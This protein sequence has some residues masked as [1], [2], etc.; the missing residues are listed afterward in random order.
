MEQPF[1]T[2]LNVAIIGGGL[3]GL[4]AARVLRE[5]H[6]VTVYERSQHGGEYGAALGFGPS[7]TAILN[8]LDFDRTRVQACSMAL[9]LAYN[10]QGELI[11][12]RDTN[13]VR[14]KLSVTGEYLLSYR[15]D[16]YTE[17]LRLATM[18]SQDLS[19]TGQPATIMYGKEAVR[20]D[21]ES[22]DVS[23]ADG[24]SVRADLVVGADGIKSVIRPFIVG[25][26]A[27]TTARPTG[28][29]AFRFV[30][31]REKVV[32]AFGS[33]PR[34]LQADQ[35]VLMTICDAA[36]GTRRF[37]N[38]YPCRNFGLLNVVCMVP[39]S[40]LKQPTTESWT[41]D[42]DKDEMVSHFAD[43]PNWVQEYLRL[44]EAPKIW[45]LRDQDP[46]PT[47]VRGR[48]IIVGDAAHSM[49][50]HQGQGA[51]QGIEDAE[52][53]RLFLSPPASRAVTRDQVPDILMDID[54]V[55]RPRASQVQA[56]TRLVASP[57]RPTEDIIRHMKFN[58][59]YEGIVEAKQNLGKTA[60]GQDNESST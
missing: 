19:V 40:S 23:F 48:A 49:T 17:F 3:V 60:N 32:E 52:A 7:V 11:F 54:A 33:V 24:S 38:C 6:T 53:F 21:T 28:L 51:T 22:G 27:F 9:T 55:R 46:L 30:L 12:T 37:S 18:P 44:A 35:P 59:I 1:Q 4:L 31:E 34:P 20:V 13:M 10:K 50:P 16:L 26:T 39:D 56:N 2:P 47:Y 57:D 15:K 58:W 14:Q 43:F 45:Q 29:S 25:D 42:G 8:S 36:D 41:A 5:Q